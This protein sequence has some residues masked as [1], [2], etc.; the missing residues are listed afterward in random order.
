LLNRAVGAYQIDNVHCA[1]LRQ[2]LHRA[3]DESLQ[4]ADFLLMKR[5]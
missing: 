5:L 1:N 2:V 3:P 4:N